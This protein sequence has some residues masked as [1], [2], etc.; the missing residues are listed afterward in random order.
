MVQRTCVIGLGEVGLPTFREIARRSLKVCGVDINKSLANDLRKQG[1]NVSTSIKRSDIYIITVYTSKQTKDV[2]RQISPK[3]KPLVL[4]EST[5]NP[6]D[7]GWFKS[8]AKRMKIDV[9]VC[10]H[11]FNPHDRHHHIFNL[12]RVLGGVTPRSFQRAY[13]Y[14]TKYMPEKK[15]IPAPSFEVAALSKVVENTYRFIEIAVA[16][17]LKIECDRLNVDFNSLRKACN[18]KWNIDIKE[19]RDGVGLHCLPKDSTIA[20]DYF[21]KS[22]MIRGAKKVDEVYKKYVKRNQVAGG[23]VK[24]NNSFPFLSLQ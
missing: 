16:E 3:N 8:Y 4:I 23:K 18:T 2:L 13:K 17:D 10:P 11:R 14:Y 6:E 9:A 5:V 19:A 1:L 22:R 12:N 20:M 21:T 24:K 15:V 7:I